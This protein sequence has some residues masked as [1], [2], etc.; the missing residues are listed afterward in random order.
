LDLDEHGLRP[1]PDCVCAFDPLVKG[2]LHYFVEK[3]IG[4]GT[5]G[6]ASPPSEASPEQRP[7]Y[8]QTNRHREHIGG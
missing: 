1:H 4:P 8:N 3:P 2:G 6:R 7:K 5:V